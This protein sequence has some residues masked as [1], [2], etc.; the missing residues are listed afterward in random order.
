MDV[1]KEIQR[2]HSRQQATKIAD[3]VGNSTARFKSLISMFSAGPYRITQRAAWPIGI[4]VERNP[5]LAAP[6]VSTL[7]RMLEAPDA[8]TA[9]KRNILRVFQFIAIPARYQGRLAACA[10]K[11]LSDKK[12][13]I[14]VRVFAMT[15]IANL[16]ATEPDLKPELRIII[17]DHLPYASPAFVSRARKVL[18]KI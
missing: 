7:L 17:E 5:T 3:Y 10:F 14:A 1:L 13:T 4:C 2:G 9:V 8:Q 15:V 6:H 12:E 18:K 16:C 11:L